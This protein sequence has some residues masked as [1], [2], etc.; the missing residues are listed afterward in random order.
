MVIEVTSRADAR[1]RNLS[2]YFTG[3]S[4]CH[5]HVCERRTSS[6]CCVECGRLWDTKYRATPK[7]KATRRRRE[8]TLAFKEKRR[9]Q[10][11]AQTNAKR[12][13]MVSPK[14][15]IV[16]RRYES[17]FQGR[18]VNRLRARLRV[19][20]HKG[21]KSGSAV[22]D[23]GC[24][25]LEF[26]KHIEKQFRPGMSWD[27]WSTHGWHL[28]HKKPLNSFDLADRMQFLAAV[29]FSNYQ[30]LWQRDNLQKRNRL[31]WQEVA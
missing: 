2:R 10:N 11:A 21:S 22:R 9:S 16:R 18:L 17:T 12:R 6:G 3:E 1:T 7:R 4:C 8:A 19:A 5:G 23:L 27:N 29:H 13:Y 31:D 20:I 30:P 15:K 14:G 26:K 25:V 24:S 28:D